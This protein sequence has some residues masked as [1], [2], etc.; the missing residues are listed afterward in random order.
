MIYSETLRPF[1][2]VR[3]AAVDAF[4]VEYLLKMRSVGAILGKGPRIRTSFLAVGRKKQR[5]KR[6][7]HDGCERAA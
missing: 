6:C 2:A 7:G 3:Y 5:I 4:P 1:E